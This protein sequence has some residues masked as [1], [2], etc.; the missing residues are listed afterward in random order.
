MLGLSACRSTEN[1]TELGVIGETFVVPVSRSDGEV[2]VTVTKLVEV[3][4]DDAELWDLRGVAAKYNVPDQ[5]SDP[6]FFFIYYS[7]RPEKGDLPPQAGS[8]WKLSTKDETLY[9]SYIMLP[10][11]DADCSGTFDDDGLGCTVVLV[12]SDAEIEMVRYYGVSKFYTRNDFGSEHW[13]G[14]AL[15]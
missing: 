15:E 11:D 12:P 4:D 2:R 3:S 10:P 8:L 1:P 6:T 13:A 5:P 7:V 14:W 9:S